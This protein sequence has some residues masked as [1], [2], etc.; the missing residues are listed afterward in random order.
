MTALTLASSIFGSPSPSS[1]LVVILHGLFG[2]KQNWNSISDTLSRKL[3][4]RVVSLDLRN[5]G[6]S[7][8]SDTMSIGSMTQDVLR[9]IH[10]DKKTSLFG[11]F[12][13]LLGH[14]MVINE[15]YLYR[16]LHGSCM[17]LGRQSCHEFSANSCECIRKIDYR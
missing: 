8:H 17:F 9:W 16:S 2:S 4:T 5:H 6:E 3:N 14:S 1:P 7:P 10:E 13:V 11:G 15:P 12:H